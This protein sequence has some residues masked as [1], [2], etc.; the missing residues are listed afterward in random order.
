MSR[1]DL[2]AIGFAFLLG[3]NAWFV[4]RLVVSID[5]FKGWVRRELEEHGEELARVDE[6]H[7]L[8]DQ[9]GPPFARQRG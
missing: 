9:I 7:K 1:E 5:E 4:R 6:R 2:L 3:V 8:E